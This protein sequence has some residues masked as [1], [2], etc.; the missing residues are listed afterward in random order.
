VSRGM[1]IVSI[2]SKSRPVNM[3]SPGLSDCFNPP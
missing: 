2:R 1:S 3:V